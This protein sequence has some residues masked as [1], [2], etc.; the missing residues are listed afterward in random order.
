MISSRAQKTY[1][2]IILFGIVLLVF[3]PSVNNEF[4]DWD[5]YLFI[6]QNGNISTISAHSVIWMWTTFYAGAWHPMTWFT[7]AADVGLWGLN[8]SPQRLENILLHCFNAVLFGLIILKLMASGKPQTAS[9]ESEDDSARLVGAAAAA[10]LFAVHPLRVE[11]VVW[12]SE[13]KDVLCVTFFLLSI[14]AYIDYAVSSEKKRYY[15]ALIFSLLAVLSKPMAITLPPVLLLLDYFP[16]NRLNR[17]D[18]WPRIREKWPFFLLSLIATIINIAAA[19]R[20]AVPFSMVPPAMRIMNAFY[21]IVFYI[22][23]SIFPHNLLPLYQVDRSLDY[24]DGRFTASAL[25]FFAITGFAVWRLVKGKKLW[26]TALAYFLITLGPASGLFMSYRHS[27][28]D[29]YSYLPTMSLWALVGLG[30]CYLWEKSSKAR[31]SSALKAAIVAGC[32]VPAVVYAGMTRG[33]MTIW[34]NSEILWTYLLEH[35]EY[36]P[37]LAYFS[38]AKILEDRGDLDGALPYYRSAVSLNPRSVKYRV[39]LAAALAKKGDEPGASAAVKEI[40]NFGPEHPEVLL[41][42]GRVLLA[43]NRN[44]EALDNFTKAL[45]KSPGNLHAMAMIIVAHLKNGDTEAAKKCFVK[46]RSQG[47]AFPTQIEAALTS[48]NADALNLDN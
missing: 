6:T 47:F 4:V 32:L 19:W 26:I 37:D 22:R 34:K 46:Y 21:A 1:L 43:M 35:A 42:V 30:I 39:R 16:L 24:F 29:R 12:I 13:R 8:P 45:A 9:D 40:Q 31:F 23:Q 36:V 15:A 38:K 5:D 3:L 7:H 2:F 25:T 17:G 20:Q 33:Q 28:A 27:M 11:S 44:A 41:G 10:L 18:F 48:A 14:S